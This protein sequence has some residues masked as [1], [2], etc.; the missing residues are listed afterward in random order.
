MQFMFFSKTFGAAETAAA[1][2]SHSLFEGQ[3]R[4]GGEVAT[5][6]PRTLAA[7]QARVSSHTQP[8]HMGARSQV[9]ALV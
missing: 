2:V 3:P 8:C 1:A 4:G 5:A 6:R 9:V 7:C